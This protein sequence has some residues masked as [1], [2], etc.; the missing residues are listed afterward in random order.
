MS[1]EDAERLLLRPMEKELRS[2]ESVKEMRSTAYLGGGNVVLEFEAGFDAQKALTDVRESV[3]RAK[4]ELPQDTDEPMVKEVNV[5]LFPVLVVTLAGEVPERTLLRLARDLRDRLETIP[6]VLSVRIAGDREELVEIVI[7]PLRVETYGLSA[8][9]LANSIS[10]NNQLIAAGQIDTGQ[11]RFAVKVPGLFESLREILDMPVKVDGDAVVRV[12][13]VAE[14]R[15]TY[16]D[17]ESYARVN[18]QP[19]IALEVS[20]RIG[21]N[22][23]E[24]IDEV[25]RVTNEEKAR[26]PDNVVVGFTQDKSDDIKMML[27]DLEN[28]LGIAV[29]L[30]MVIVLGSLGM[31]S[32]ILVGVAIVGSF[33]AAILLLA[34]MGLTINIVVLFGLIFAAGNVVDG[35]IVVTEFADRRMAEG[36]GRAEAYRM[37]AKRMSWPIISAIGTQIAAFLPL[38]FWPG[39]VGQFMKY[40]PITQLVVLSASVLM[41][42]VFIPVLGAWFGR[43]GKADA[44]P[45]EPPPDDATT[46]VYVGMLAW[47]LRRPVTVLLAT[48]VALVGVQWWYATHGNGVEFFPDVEPD[49]ALLNVQARGNLST[50]EKDRLNR[51]VEERILALQAERGEFATIYS[52]TRVRELGKDAGEDTIGIIQ[53]EFADWQ[54]R[55]K[56][57]AILADIGQRTRDLAGI[58][59][60]TRRQEAGPPIGKPIQVQLDSRDP[61]LL[62]PAVQHVRGL[63]SRIEGLKD[64]ED[65]RPLPGVEWQ[66]LVDRGQAAKFGADVA[67]VGSS[68]RLVTNGLKFGE[69]RPDDSDDEIDI[70]ARYPREDRG[71]SQLGLVRVQTAS[72]LVPIENFVTRKAAP[73]VSEIQRVDG[74]RAMMVKADV[75][76][77]LLPDDKVREFRRLLEAE[78]V[79]LGV[80]VR[81]KGQD[82]EQQK[83]QEFLSKAF[84][85]AIFLIFV[86][87]LAQFNSLYTTFV[88]LTGV[89]MSTI[90]VFVG[91]LVTGQPFGIVMTGIG[92]VALAGIVVQNNIVL[93]DT[94]DQLV[95]TSPSVREALLQTGR[96]RLRPVL[97][98]AFNTVLGLL[99]LVLGINI[100]LFQR[101]ITIDAPATQWWIGLSTAICFGLGFS[102]ILTL[103]VTPCALMVRGNVAGWFARRRLARGGG[104]HPAPAE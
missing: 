93:I 80:S 4:S 42:L 78:P 18:G 28:N 63:L 55:R 11:G 47:S 24:T 45:V 9:D 85:A 67:S 59:V 66:I 100:D 23:I 64:I 83:A 87:L 99:P 82:E 84:L 57:S 46:R 92:V 40:L 89:V 50:D 61:A 6:A 73:R 48:V 95:Q 72:G 7:D 103:L 14:V 43:A 51:E 71:I 2:V 97:L 94:F 54:R 86:I 91:L 25:R 13:D 39:V 62:E 26:W 70:V 101:A 27:S 44:T 12:R 90:G 77:G 41:A 36:M 10:R 20:K 76:A 38:L 19:A 8:T 32:T 96:E 29:L 53:L 68:I 21:Q 52:S 17:R 88:I 31:R 1:P 98:T 16:K 33:L 3:N 56:A 81:F 37:A 15:R 58:H 5:S 22:I 49:L 34:V 75:E 35:A 79:A 74:R 104:G 102:T 65:S 60:E 30:V 69:Y